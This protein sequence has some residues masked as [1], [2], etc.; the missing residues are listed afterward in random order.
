MKF[1][2]EGSI[3]ALRRGAN[4]IVHPN[5]FSWASVRGLFFRREGQEETDGCTRPSATFQVL[6]DQFPQHAGGNGASP[7]DMVEDQ[8]GAFRLGQPRKQFFGQMRVPRT[9]GEVQSSMQ[10]R[11]QGAEDA[12]RRL[13][14]PPCAPPSSC[15]ATRTRPRRAPISRR[16]FLFCVH[17]AKGLEYPESHICSRP[18][19]VEPRRLTRRC[20]A[21]LT[22]ADLEV[23]ELDYR[24]AKDKTDKSL[25]LN[26]FYV[27]ALYVSITRAIG[28]PDDRGVGRAA[29]PALCVCSIS[30][31]RSRDR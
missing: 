6:H 10:G 8:T 13:A 2:D 27:N 15:C 14:R 29:P 30:K 18:G 19:L 4:Q 12:R 11:R 22:A 9:T 3:P 16:R 31:A 1:E 26:K 25:E 24:R 23:D 20:A 5:F 28:E 21:R 17:E 7:T